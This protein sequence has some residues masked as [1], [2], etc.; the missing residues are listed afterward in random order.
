MNNYMIKIE[1]KFRA[2]HRLLPPYKGKCNNVHGE[3]YTA[4]IE[5]ESEK[6][7]ENGMVI[8]FGTI[9]SKIKE[10]I[11]NNWD[12]SYLFN[13]DDE[14]GRYLFNKGMKV[15]NIG[16]QNPTAENM[17]EFLFYII[18]YTI[19]SRVKRVGIIESFEDSIA[20]YEVKK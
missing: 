8:D 6:L 3:G 5:L 20:Y 7:D 16:K 17:A 12:H 4:I 1:L 18:K 9:K 15:F 13:G 10:W 2:G 11:D 19:F 14:I